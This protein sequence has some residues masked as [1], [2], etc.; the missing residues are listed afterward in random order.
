MFQDLAGERLVWWK[1][2]ECPNTFAA[3]GL[4]QLNEI[5]SIYERPLVETLSC[6]NLHISSS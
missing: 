3:P 2:A 4:F 6:Q 1:K 5:L